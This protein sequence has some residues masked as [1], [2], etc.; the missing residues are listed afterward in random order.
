L[1]EYIIAF[2]ISFVAG[3]ACYYFCKWLE[4]NDRDN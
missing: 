4:D 3:V 1:T 2:I